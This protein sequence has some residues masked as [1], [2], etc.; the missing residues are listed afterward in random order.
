MSAESKVEWCLLWLGPCLPSSEWSNWLQAAMSAAAVFA[1]IGV[2]WWQMRTKNLQ[3]RAAALLA[4][5]G[6]LALANQTIGGLQAVASGLAER[7]AGHV[8]PSNE[9]SHLLRVLDNLPL[10][11]REDLVA[12]NLAFPACSTKA[13]RVSNCVQQLRAALEWQTRENSGTER[14]LLLELR[15]LAEAAAE[16]FIQVR[17][18]LDGLCPK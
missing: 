1:A 14:D 15:R 2:V 11:S 17:D 9:L 6:I 18:E 13:L 7:A 10:P 16:S 12:L 3:D 8:Q 4:G 5:S